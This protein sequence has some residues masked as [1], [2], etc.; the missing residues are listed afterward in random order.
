MLILVIE[1]EEPTRRG[2]QALLESAG[3]TVCWAESGESALTL[4]RRE[5]VDL[6]LL[7]MTLKGRISG[8]DLA[9]YK[10]ANPRT[11]AIPLIVTTAAEEEDVRDRSRAD[12]L[13]DAKCI[14][15]KPFDSTKLMTII[16]SINEDTVID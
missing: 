5:P 15:S 9:W 12:V 6:V 14:L 10:Y 4:L 2:L 11:R 3:H 16:N 13:A 8:W 1:D 7:D